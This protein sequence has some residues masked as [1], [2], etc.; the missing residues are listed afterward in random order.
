MGRRTQ[1][2][3]FYIFRVFF[4]VVSDNFFKERARSFW[5]HA[6]AQRVLSPQSQKQNLL[7]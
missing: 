6:E 1:K 3:L 7:R 4:V 2:L 5:P